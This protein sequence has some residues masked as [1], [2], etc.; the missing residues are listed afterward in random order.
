MQQARTERLYTILKTHEHRNTDIESRIRAKLIENLKLCS[1]FD[2]VEKLLFQ[3]D[4]QM[5]QM[6]TLI[7]LDEL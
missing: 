4:Y 1:D 7:I 2:S 6:G 3:F 5:K